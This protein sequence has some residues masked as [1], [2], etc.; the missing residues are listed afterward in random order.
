MFQVDKTKKR[1]PRE[2]EPIATVPGV[3]EGIGAGGEAC[4]CVSANYWKSG[5]G[6]TNEIPETHVRYVRVPPIMTTSSQ[7]TIDPNQCEQL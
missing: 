4:E 3:L 5:P 2:E 6:S 1:K 7:P